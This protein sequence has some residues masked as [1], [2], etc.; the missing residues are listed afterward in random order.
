MTCGLCGKY[1]WF[2]LLNDVSLVIHLLLTNESKNISFIGGESSTAA[3]TAAPTAEPPA[4]FGKWR[5]CNKY[6]WRA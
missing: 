1:N 5:K 6:E 3:P 4:E 2:S